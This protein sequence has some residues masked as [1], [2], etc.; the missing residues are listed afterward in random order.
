MLSL[1]SRTLALAA[2]L[3]SMILFSTVQPGWAEDKHDG[4]PNFGQVSETLFRGA[5][6]KGAGFNAL[7]EM[8]VSIVVN[9]RHER[10]EIASEQRQVEA[11]GMKFVSIPWRGEDEPSSKQVAQFLDLV[12]DNPT[13]K[14]FVHCKAGA[15]RTGVMVAAYEIVN[16]HKSIDEAVAEMHRYHYHEFRL[17]HLQEYVKSLPRLLQSEQAFS[18]YSPKA[19]AP[20]AAPT[21]T[22]AI[23][24]AAL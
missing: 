9:F 18:A 14:I 6:P 2:I 23:V 24:P 19:P 22:V 20:A 1:R 15:D 5:Q 4:L 11:A 7:H 12:R 10:D 21:P 3:S 17:A 16:G 13:A 8:G